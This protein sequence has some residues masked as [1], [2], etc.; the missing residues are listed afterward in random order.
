MPSVPGEPAG[1]PSLARGLSSSR[2]SQPSC[3]RCPAPPIPALPFLCLGIESSANKVGVGIASSS[4]E[5][6]SNPRCTFVTPPGTGF[7]PRE[8]ALH[9]QEKIVGLVKTALKDAAVEPD[10]LRCI[11]YTCGPGMGAPLAVGAVT[12]RTLSLLWKLPL[13]AANHCVAHIEM[14]RL[15]TECRNPV[16]L[17]VSGGNTQVIGYSEGRY[18][19]LGETLDVAVGNCIDRLARLLHLANEPAPG[20]QVEQLAKRFLQERHKQRRLCTCSGQ[21][22]S[23]SG[24]KSHHSKVLECCRSTHYRESDEEQGEMEELLPLPYAVKGMDLSFSGILTRLEDLAGVMYRYRKLSESSQQ[25]SNAYSNRSP[26][27]QSENRAGGPRSFS[28]RAG[29]VGAQPE[30]GREEVKE[31][32]DRDIASSE[33]PSAD[34]V[35]TAEDARKRKKK[36]Y[37]AVG[38]NTGKEGKKNETKYKKFDRE[39]DAFFEGIPVHLLTPESLCYSA[40]E[41][42]FAMLTEVTER[43]MALYH[44]DQVLVVGGV[45]CN[46][47][48]QQMLREMAQARG[49][50]MGAMDD[51]YCIDNGAMVAYVGCLLAAKGQFVDV[52]KAHYRQ[53]FRTDEVPVLWREG[54]SEENP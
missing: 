4:G 18:R 22:D 41:V 14:G 24:M 43:A 50:S 48:L 35:R 25:G 36:A 53:R 28:P 12:A 13:V 1:L 23:A 44:A 3:G 11:A 27:D 47:R 45:G 49:A 2:A 16:I 10:Q 19:I 33:V 6:L 29:D 52:G 17:Y 37:C 31:A 5:I 42:I 21:R 7:L 32:L 30:E 54:E 8:T 26:E 15:V 34:S 38:T 20:Y 9:H 40:Q 46:L 51:R 39:G